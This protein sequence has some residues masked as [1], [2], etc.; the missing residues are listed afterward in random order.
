MKTM[1]QYYIAVL[2]RPGA[3]NWGWDQRVSLYRLAVCWLVVCASF[4]QCL[5]TARAAEFLPVGEPDSQ[6]IQLQ[7]PTDRFQGRQMERYKA[8]VRQ[9]DLPLITVTT[10]VLI[11]VGGVVKTDV[12]RLAQLSIQEKE[13]LAGQFSI[14][15]GVIERLV[16][17]VASN[18]PPAADQLAQELRAAVIDYKFL[19]I[20]WDRFHPPAEGQQTKSNAVAALQSG[21]LAKAWEL[22]DGLARPGAPAITRPAP[23]TNLKVVPEP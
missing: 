16:E 5:A 4:L 9:A 1:K 18:S 13:A 11:E 7:K 21:D 23:P 8:F 19:E 15:V 2:R 10:N 12:A 6:P 14:P 3:V 17:R 20:E 22:Y